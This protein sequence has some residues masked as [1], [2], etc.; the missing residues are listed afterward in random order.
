[1]AGRNLLAAGEEIA[2]P[3]PSKKEPV[4]CQEA[5][6]DSA[7]LPPTLWYIIIGF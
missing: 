6:P 5:L 2:V 3:K 1:M 7:V 4:T